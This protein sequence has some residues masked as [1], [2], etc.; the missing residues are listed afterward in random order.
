VALNPQRPGMQTIYNGVELAVEQ[1]N[2]ERAGK[3]TRLTVRKTPREVTGAIEIATILRDDPTVVG[4]V[5]HPESGSTLDAAAVYEDSEGDGERAVVAISP[6]ATSPALT[7]RSEW[8]FRVCPTDIAASAATARFVLDSLGTRRASI[9]YRNDPYGKD[10]TRAF[11]S[12]YIAGGGT[13]LQRDPYLAGITEWEAY[14][15]YVAMLSPDV[16]LFPGSSEDAELA[17]RALRAAGVRVPIVGGDAIAPLEMKAA[18]FAGVRY[19]AFFQPEAVS[20]DAGRAFVQA[21]RAKFG[22]APD[23]RA[24]LAFDAAMIIGRAALATGGN[25]ARIRDHV[26]NIGSSTRTLHHGATGRIAFDAR[27][28]V[29]GKPVVIAQVGRR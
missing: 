21:Y 26:S 18:E 28:D 2:R 22:E 10:W 29:I 5:G 15:A 14:A 19:T 25:R 11:A 27:H 13:V 24:A 3:G 7:G 1:L 6:T 20:T 12:A 16:I 8:V 23:Q 17:I 4:V 9:I